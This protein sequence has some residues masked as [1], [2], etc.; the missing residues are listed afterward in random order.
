MR[1]IRL[2]A[3]GSV[4]LTLL[5]AVTANAAPPAATDKALLEQGR[6]VYNF[7]CYYCHGYSGDA[8]TLAAGFLTP[9]P[10]AFTAHTPQAMPLARIEKAA[11]DGRPGTG[12]KPFRAVI[13]ESE[14][15]AVAWFVFDEFVRRKA[16]NTRYHT[17]ENGWPRHERYGDAFPFARGEVSLAVPP[18]TLSPELQR[19]RALF[20]RSCVSCHD[21]GQPDGERL[22]WNA[23]PLS[24]PRHNYDHRNPEVDAT[25]SATPYRLHDVPPQLGDASAVVRR[26][27]RLFQ[28]NCAFCHAADGTGKGWIGRFLEPHARDLTDP[29]VMR[30]MTRARLRTTIREGLPDTSMPAWKSVL[31]DDDVEALI[32]YIDRAFHPLSH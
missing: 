20:V 21:R 4:L 1:F 7:R 30:T 17:P 14:I 28:D 27:E 12:M 29:A 3:G 10:T 26:G 23:R 24:Y 18:E 15:R 13:P 11:R 16:T 22:D 9:P 25:S 6:K 5:V 32:A 31:A 2:Q 8:K 19:G